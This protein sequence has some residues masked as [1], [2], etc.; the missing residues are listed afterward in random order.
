MCP[1]WHISLGHSRHSMSLQSKKQRSWATSIGDALVP[2]FIHVLVNH[3]LGGNS[4]E[5]KSGILPSY[6]ALSRHLSTSTGLLTD[7]VQFGLELCPASTVLD[8]WWVGYL[9]ERHSLLSSQKE[10]S[11]TKRRKRF[12]Y[13]Y[14]INRGSW[15][16]VW[17]R[18]DW[19]LRVKD[20]VMYAWRI[21]SRAKAKLLGSAPG[22]HQQYNRVTIQ[23]SAPA[24][25][26]FPRILANKV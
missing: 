7:Q 4:I 23:L 15:L 9:I 14:S 11:S 21:K 22:F 20:S 8:P 16:P 24:N 13:R 6:L 5:S 18:V 25:V 2:L 1:W 10:K 3:G 19:D 12:S 17:A 26:K